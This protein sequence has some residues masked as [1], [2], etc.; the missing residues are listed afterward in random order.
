MSSS[1]GHKSADNPPDF[2]EDHREAL[3]EI[4]NIGMGAAGDSLARALDTFV[5]LSIPRIRL[6]RADE[7]A[8]II[9]E[10]VDL[11]TDVTAVRQ[12]FFSHWLG[13]TITIFGQQDSHELGE[14]LHYPADLDSNAET[15]LF[16]DIANIISGACLN[17]IAEN[18]AV[19]LSFSPPT[20]LANSVRTNEILAGL[21]LEWNYTLLLEV[22]FKLEGH[23]F[24][25]H[26]FSLI[27]QASIE[28]LCQDIDRF[29]EQ[30]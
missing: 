4:A 25:T 14:L 3:Q 22:N 28:T 20:L 13:E 19:E 2:S 10:M 5:Q 9:E 15:E 24:T 1:T 16:L 7:L 30:Y 27:S 29:L 21:Q 8:N 12:A 18:L 17:G 11:N 26:L 23:D 6:V